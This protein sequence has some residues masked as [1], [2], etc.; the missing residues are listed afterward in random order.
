MLFFLVSIFLIWIGHKGVLCAS[1]IPTSIR[2]RF[3]SNLQT[4][5]LRGACG[6]GAIAYVPLSRAMDASVLA[7]VD[8]KDFLSLADRANSE[9]S[10]SLDTGVL[11][12]DVLY[13]QWLDGDWFVSSTTKSV[14]APLGLEAFGG[15][16][17]WEAAQKDIGNTLKYK[18]RF[19][20]SP[21]TGNG[22]IADRIFNVR[23]IAT[24]A[25]GKD[26]IMTIGGPREDSKGQAPDFDALA[27]EL[28]VSMSPNQ[29]AGEIFDVSLATTGRIY[30]P[31][32][33]SK[34]KV[35]ESTFV[36][37]EKVQQVISRRMDELMSPN[38]Q[39]VK[40]I[41]TISLYKRE[42]PTRVAGIQR[43][44]TFLSPLEQSSRFRA[45]A[46]K[47]SRVKEQA[48]D[49]RLYDLIYEKVT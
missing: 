13:P 40:V 9:A 44:A 26:S 18:S 23:S 22:V 16:S 37:M 12:K 14:Y 38:T 3:A 49:I 21:E 31:N 43:T 36:A 41:E 24:A 34:S 30:Y 45:L 27:Q 17:A 47:D 19:L 10:S 5:L 6:V 35:D 25:V 48:V 28:R 20:N 7:G 39:K 46:E 42:S 33:L 4:M 32:A 29:I 15:S 11:Y 2:N 1:G 8:D